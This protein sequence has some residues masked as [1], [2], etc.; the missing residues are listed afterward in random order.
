MI[1][2]ALVNKVYNIEDQLA[3]Y[4]ASLLYK[5]NTVI[6]ALLNLSIELSKNIINNNFTQPKMPHK[7]Y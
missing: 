4:I 1:S 7:L 5:I 6:K 3:L 2:R